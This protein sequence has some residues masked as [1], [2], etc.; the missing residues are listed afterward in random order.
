MVI[1]LM[2]LPIEE[3]LSMWVLLP[4]G[5]VQELEQMPPPRIE[6]KQVLQLSTFPHPQKEELDLVIL[7]HIMER[8]LHRKWNHLHHSWPHVKWYMLHSQAKCKGCQHQIIHQLKQCRICWSNTSNK[9]WPLLDT[10]GK[11]TTNSQVWSTCSKQQFIIICYIIVT[12]SSRVGGQ[13]I[14]GQMGTTEKG[15]MKK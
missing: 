14:H 2:L 13:I 15:W 12:H 9:A 10:G 11:D 8:L 4:E 1:L 5:Q 7:Q 6:R 3:K